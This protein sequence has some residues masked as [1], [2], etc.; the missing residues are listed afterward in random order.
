MSQQGDSARHA[1]CM[2]QLVYTPWATA[3]VELRTR[4]A[5]IFAQAGLALWRET[6]QLGAGADSE[7]PPDGTSWTSTTLNISLLA[8]DSEDPSPHSQQAQRILSA[9]QTQLGV[10]CSYVRSTFPTLPLGVTVSSTGNSA[11]FERFFTSRSEHTSH[12]AFTIHTTPQEIQ[13]GINVLVDGCSHEPDVYGWY[14]A[15][16][17][18]QRI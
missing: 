5:H 9:V 16:R 15:E 18:W 14:A 7:A 11:R 10:A 17:C 2:I 1:V 4:I 13:E 6:T 12:Y 3:S 8:P